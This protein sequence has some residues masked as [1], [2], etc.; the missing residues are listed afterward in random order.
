MAFRST[1][2][3][4]IAAGIVEPL[5]PAGRVRVALRISAMFLVGLVAIPLIYLWMLLP[6]P[7]PW[8]RF[9]LGW[10]AWINGARVRVCGTPLR[11]NVFFISNHVSWIDIL[12]LASTSG[13]AF[14]SKQEIGEAPIVGWLAGLNRTIY[15][16]R[17]DRIRVA[18]Q[19]NQL[20]EAMVEAWSVTIFPEGTT[21]D[22]RSLLPFKTSMLRVLEPPPPG[23]LVQPIVL[24]YGPVGEEIAW[25]GEESGRHNAFRLMARRGS[26][27]VDVHYL[28]PFHPRDFPGRKNIAAEARRRIEARMHELFGEPVKPFGGHDAWAGRVPFPPGSRIPEGAEIAT[29]SEAVAVPAQ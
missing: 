12:A 26:F 13:T 24:D 11:R 2:R 15:V 9:F 14:V 4:R 25:L 6:F 16:K 5:S 23:I 27:R 29:A 3:A 22:G 7:S 19:I 17:E 10:C 28:E 18:E 1:A 21:T 20:Q 8:Q